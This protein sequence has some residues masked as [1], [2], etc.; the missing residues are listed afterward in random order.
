I[1]SG[2]SFNP[3]VKQTPDISLPV[4]DRPIGG[5]GIFLVKQIMNEVKYDRIGNKNI[6]TMV[7]DIADYA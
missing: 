5:L 1:D 4:S 3:T 2:I 7:K 6:L